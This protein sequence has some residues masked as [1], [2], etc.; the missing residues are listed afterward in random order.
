MRPPQLAIQKLA[1]SPPLPE[2]RARAGCETP[3]ISAGADPAP[4]SRKLAWSSSG[5]LAGFCC[6]VDRSKRQ[7]PPPFL[8]PF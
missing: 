3:A 2:S 7:L 4:P 6:G 1:K 5:P 8:P